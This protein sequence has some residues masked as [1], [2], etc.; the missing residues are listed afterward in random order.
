MPARNAGGKS[1]KI[2]PS[3][4]AGAEFAQ[5]VRRY[6]KAHAQHAVTSSPVQKDVVEISNLARV[7]SQEDQA[8]SVRWELIEKVKAQISDGTY[9]SPDKIDQVVERLFKDLDQ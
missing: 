7:L 2:N 3:N 9:D 5:A 8:Q 6:E 1:I 4:Q